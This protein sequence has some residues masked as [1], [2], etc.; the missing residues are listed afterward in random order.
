MVKKLI[1]I[2]ITAMIF[3]A[4]SS[5]SRYNNIT[6]HKVKSEKVKT[7]A[8]SKAS[9]QIETIE[10]STVS[11]LDDEKRGGVINSISAEELPNDKY[12]D[13]KRINLTKPSRS[14][15]VENSANKIQDNY[16]LPLNE[17]SELKVNKLRALWTI[18]L[19]LGLVVSL[20]GLVVLYFNFYL[21]VLVGHLL[22]AL[23]LTFFIFKMKLFY[24][25]KEKVYINDLKKRLVW[26]VFLILGVLVSIGL[27]MMIVLLPF[28]FSL[29]ILAW[30][31]LSLS[32][33]F[34]IYKMIRVYRRRLKE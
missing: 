17:K 30:I 22:F 24:P 2:T 18:L 10:L 23:Y 8:K 20:S 19:I 1:Q 5:C 3:V 13:E 26:T 16:N 7:T 14:I 29:V 28:S 25:P 21:L 33:S 31:L 32:F 27:S 34:F 12:F 15:K 9:I 6:F 4:I 11:N